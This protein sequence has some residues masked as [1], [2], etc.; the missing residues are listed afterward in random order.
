MSSTII[1]FVVKK[2]GKYTFN[3]NTD[4]IVDDGNIYNNRDIA[5]N[6][7]ETS[8][9]QKTEFNNSNVES[10]K[11]MKEDRVISEKTK[12]RA[13]LIDLLSTLSSQQIPERSTF[14]FKSTNERG[15]KGYYW[16]DKLKLSMQGQC[17]W[18]TFLEVSRLSRELGYKINLSLRSKTTGQLS[19]YFM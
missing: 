8:I 12:L 15:V 10:F 13:V 5:I 19:Y 14:N 1:Q 7:R 9:P 6:E 16:C 4:R 2:E 17:K 11:I 3:I 18:R